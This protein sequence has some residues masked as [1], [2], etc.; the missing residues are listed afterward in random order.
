M[1]PPYTFRQGQFLAFI[2]HYTTLHG[3]PPAETEMVQFFQ[4]TPPTVHQMI[5]TLERH[6]L[7]TRAPGQARSIKMTLSPEILP[8]LS[9]VSASTGAPLPVRQTQ[10]QQ[11]TDTE[12]AVLRL[13]KIQ[14][15]D[16]FVHYDLNSLDDSE[17][18]PLLDTLIESF[19]RAGLSALAVKELRRQACELYHGCCQEALPESTMESNMKLM[20]SYLPGP[21][22]T[23]W[24]RLI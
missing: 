6:G 13:G 19:A 14:M 5:L 16:L 2:H 24:L 7:I 10:G 4:V 23:I 21:R 17:F 15:K 9:G 1:K 11:P 12:A 18:I 8:P 20:F 3:R 22:R